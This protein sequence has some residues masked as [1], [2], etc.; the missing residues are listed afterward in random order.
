MI[1]AQKH[2][3]E[4]QRIAALRR[5]KI[6]D[7]PP[8]KDIDELTLIALQICETPIALL[9]LIDESRQWFKSKHGLEVTETP[10]DLAICAHTIMS[11]GVFIVTDTALDHRFSDNPLICGANSPIVFYAGVPLISPDGYPIGTLSVVDHKPRVLTENQKNSLL[12]LSNQITRLLEMKLQL[13]Q[14]DI[15]AQRLQYKKTAIENLN[16]GIVLQDRN[17]NIIDFN[18]AALEVLGLTAKQLAGQTSIDPKGRAIKED[19]SPFPASEHPVALALASGKK[20]KATV[21][22]IYRPNEELRWIE[23]NSSPI[24][25]DDQSK[26]S[27]VVT[28]FS[29]ETQKRM[30]KVEVDKNEAY[31]KRVLDTIPGLIGHWNK[32]LINL[33]ANEAYSKYFGKT[34]EEIKGQS[35]LS[36]L[37][38]DLYKLNYPYVEKTLQGQPQIFEIS[39]VRPNGNIR[40]TLVNYLPEYENNEV[41]GFFVITTDISEVKRLESERQ[42]LTAKMIES[43]KLSSLG[44]MAG[45]IAHEINTPLAII[46]TKASMLMEKYSQGT[47]TAEDALKQIEKIKVTAERISKIVKGLRL[48]SRNSEN[49]PLENFTVSSVLDATLDLCNERI[50]N[51]KIE[52]RKNI[53]SDFLISGKFTE[54]SQVIMNLMSNS[55]DA[56][57]TEN[58]KWIKIETSLDDNLC[59]ISITDSGLGIPND[60]IEKMMNPFFTTKEI[61]KGTGL[62]LSISNGI[63]KSHGGILKYDTKSMHTRFTIQLPAAKMNLR[64]FNL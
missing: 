47:A 43:A 32:D 8:E 54:I 25:P 57:Q 60:V 62:G 33:N 36:V 64:S 7:T 1:S 51:F 44:E 59:L 55:I 63:I 48:F 30:A 14:L 17:L 2:P 50:K 22:G 10:R 26:T 40:Y 29:D 53:I 24:F 39:K 41:V 9:S 61:G 16:E 12:A 3:R 4:S 34:P 31:L 6:L 13:E 49:D 58:D 21:M 38:E 27:F 18:S 45:G 37:G 56:I 5:L 23:V 46:T 20:Q 42:D 35:L 52:L 11:D 15:D 28:S 19:G